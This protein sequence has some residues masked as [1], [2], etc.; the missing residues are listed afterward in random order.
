VVA[1]VESVAAA[2]WPENVSWA[3][4]HASQSLGAEMWSN[5]NPA[6]LSLLP[7]FGDSAQ[8][9]AMI[10]HGTECISKSAASFLGH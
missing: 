7:L 3:A 9:L 6:L 10:K 1:I 4:Y 5:A 8:S 2:A